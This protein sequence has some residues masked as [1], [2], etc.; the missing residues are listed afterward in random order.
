[1]RTVEAT[2]D[3]KGSCTC[4]RASTYRGHAEHSW[5][6]WRNLLS[7]YRKRRYW[8]RQRRRRTGSGLKRMTHGR[9]FS[10]SSG[11][12]TVLGPVAFRAASHGSPGR[13]RSRRL[14]LRQVASNPY[15]NRHSIVLSDNA[16]VAGSLQCKSYA[17][18]GELFAAN[19]ELVVK[20][21][22]SSNGEARKHM[23]DAVVGLLKSSWR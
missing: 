20:Q 9:T 14:V 5:P 1:M 8:A 17:R 15:S 13:R 23:V 18:P 10:G 12:R 21:V 19:H 6:F 3:E 22:G 7:T 16:L 2:I 4:A 11:P